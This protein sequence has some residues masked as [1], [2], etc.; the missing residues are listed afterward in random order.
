MAPETTVDRDLDIAISQFAPSAE[1]VKD[2]VIHTAAGV[3]DYQ[4]HGNTVVQ[5]PDPFRATDSS[6]YLRTMSSRGP[7]YAAAELLQRLRRD[8]RR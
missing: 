2:G 5:A 6:W 3:V 7:V 8:D 1:T 4:R